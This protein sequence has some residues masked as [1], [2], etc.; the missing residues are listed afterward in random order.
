MNG[1]TL[2]GAAHEAAAAGTAPSSVRLSFA[3]GL[4]HEV[5]ARL[6]R[7]LGAA[8]LVFGPNAGTQSPMPPQVP[9]QKT[10]L[11]NKDYIVHTA[12]LDWLQKGCILAITW[13]PAWCDIK[14]R[15][16]SCLL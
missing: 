4:Y 6:T 3:R 9:L 12:L 2:D 13:A 5:G 14:A 1:A 15:L 16:T 10:L 11:P 8:H 7:E